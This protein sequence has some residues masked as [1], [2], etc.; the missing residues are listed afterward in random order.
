MG[1]RREQDPRLGG[2]GDLLFGTHSLDVL[3]GPGF[4]V[5]PLG[6]VPQRQ[7]SE[8]GGQM[9]GISLKRHQLQGHGTGLGH[10]ALSLQRLA[11]SRAGVCMPGSRS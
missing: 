4:V 6:T 5:H 1:P 3:G 9:Q 8:P 2:Q 7:V 11:I 10:C